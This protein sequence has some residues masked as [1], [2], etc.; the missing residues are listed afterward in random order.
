MLEMD[1]T[2]MPDFIFAR[3]KSYDIKD[4]SVFAGRVFTKYP[5]N[6]PLTER[7]AITIKA[8]VQKLLVEADAGRIPDDNLVAIWEGNIDPPDV[9]EIPDGILERWMATCHTIDICVRPIQDASDL[10]SSNARMN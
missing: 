2:N 9:N 10:A 4:G 3:R 5:K 6:L 7:E 1:F 8:V